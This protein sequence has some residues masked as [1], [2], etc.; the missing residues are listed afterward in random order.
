MGLKTVIHIVDKALGKQITEEQA[1]PPKLGPV[2]DSPAFAQGAGLVAA[3]VFLLVGLAHFQGDLWFDE[4]LTVLNYATAERLGEVFTSYKVANNHILFSALLWGWLRLFGQGNEAFLRLPCLLLALATLYLLYAH[5]RRLFGH[6]AAGLFVTLLMAFSPIY[7]GFYSQLRGYTLTI[8]LATLATIGGLNIITGKPRRGT[9]MFCLGAVLL[10]VVIPSN[11][12]LNLSLLAFVNLVL[13]RRGKWLA[14]LFYQIAWVPSCLVGM[15]VYV[16]IWRKFEKVMQDTASWDSGSRVVLHWL[17]ALAAHGGL[18]MAACYGL[19]RQ[20]EVRQMP[21]EDRDRTT[22]DLRRQL[23][24]LAGCCLVPLFLV[25]WIRAPFPRV[26]LCYLPP[27]TFAA[28]VFYSPRLVRV[29]KYLYLTIFFVLANFLVWTRL[30]NHFMVRDLA[31]GRYRQN[32]LQQYHARNRDIS[33]TMAFLANEAPLPANAVIFVDFQLFVAA[34]Q[35]WRLHERDIGAVECLACPDTK[36]GFRL[37]REIEHYPYLPTLILAYSRRQAVRKFKQA[38]GFE[39]RL[40]PLPSP[41]RLTI[42]RVVGPAGPRPPFD[43]PVLPPRTDLP[44][45]PPM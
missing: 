45:G 22:L 23:P 11:L 35:Y 19:R 42:F 27:L 41:T 3:L 5:G 38:T 20:K 10:P 4:W 7:I 44:T 34:R 25:A 17:L 26:F 40:E 13:A 16:P 6:A 32:L 43:R 24:W 18:F 9:V 29:N 12:M 14:H 21:E 2:A 15:G 37:Q 33:R 28:M 1:P 30:A 31:R 39:I 36:K 8:F